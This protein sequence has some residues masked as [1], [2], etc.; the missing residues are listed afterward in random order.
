MFEAC[1][2]AVHALEH[3]VTSGTTSEAARPQPQGRRVPPGHTYC[4]YDVASDEAHPQLSV[5]PI[6]LISTEFALHHWRQI[7][8]SRSCI[9]YG[10][11]QGHIRVLSRHSA[12]RAL[13]KGHTKPLTDLQFAPPVLAGS[14]DGAAAS[15]L[16]LASGG[17]DGL[18]HVWQLHLDKDAAGIHET[19]QL[20]ASF[21][22][23]AGTGCSWGLS[24]AVDLVASSVSARVACREPGAVLTARPA[25]HWSS[26]MSLQAPQAKCC[27]HGMCLTGMCW[28]LGLAAECCCLPCLQVARS[29]WRLIWRPTRHRSKTATPVREAAGRLGWPV[30]ATPLQASGFRYHALLQVSLWCPTGAAKQ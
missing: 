11:K 8:I 7:A 2:A 17:Q 30:H 18:L 23:G 15:G 28:L 16:L 14:R 20:C 5:N 24:L 6:T 10:L 26:T 29:S 21:L 27:F 4:T 25:H 9:C 19:Q 13:L 12:L 22:S 1:S 3:A